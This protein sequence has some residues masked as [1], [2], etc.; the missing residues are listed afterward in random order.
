M[1]FLKTFP[2]WNKFPP[3]NYRYFQIRNCPKEAVP[4]LRLSD[5]L[6]ILCVKPAPP[7][8]SSDQFMWK[9]KYFMFACFLF[10]I[11]PL[12]SR[13][14][15]QIWPTSVVTESVYHLL[16]VQWPVW[17]EVK[18]LYF[19]LGVCVY[20]CVLKVL[21]SHPERPIGNFLIVASSRKAKF[22]NYLSWRVFEGCVFVCLLVTKKLL[23]Y[24]QFYS[25]ISIFSSSRE[26]FFPRFVTT[27]ISWISSPWL[28]VIDP[29]YMC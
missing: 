20:M 8:L 7:Y 14:Q 22:N 25:R 24:H 23:L 9:S 6:M 28:F 3:P 13:S 11:G 4:F 16:T 10:E 26:G 12:T 15:V 21:Q 1:E 2:T 5:F 27:I 19:V 17:N 29:P 18:E